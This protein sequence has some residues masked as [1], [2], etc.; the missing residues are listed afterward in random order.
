MELITD[1]NIQGVTVQNSQ[2]N[3]IYQGV[4]LGTGTPDAGGPEG[5]RIVQNL[6][7]NIAKQGISIGAVA[8]NISAY[9]IFLN[10]ANDLFFHFFLCLF[11]FSLIVI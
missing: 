5:V 9:N 11:T 2:F 4:M 7:D 3:N 10:V 1:E 8:L 6:F